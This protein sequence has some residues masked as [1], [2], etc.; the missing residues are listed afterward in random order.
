[1][2]S[3]ARSQI[4]NEEFRLFTEVR[5]LVTKLPDIDLGVDHFDHKIELSCHMLARAVAEIFSLEFVDGYFTDG[6]CHSWILTKKGN[7]IDVYPVAILGG[8]ILMDASGF[9]PARF[10][11][12]KINEELEGIPEASW[13]R[14]PSEERWFKESVEKIKDELV[15]IRSAEAKC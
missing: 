10:L 5:E 9:S 1:M 15:K 12:K 8:P 14:V 2:T 7:I 3:Y 6:Y 13:Y 4:S 11:Y